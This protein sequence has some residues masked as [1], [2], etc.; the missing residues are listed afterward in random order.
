M[1]SQVERII[2]SIRNILDTTRQPES[3]PGLVDLNGV[4]EDLSILVMPET[5][6]KGIR[7]TKTFA[8]DLPLVYGSRSKLEE[9][10]LNLIDNAID[11]LPGAGAITIATRRVPSPE[12]L[13][14]KTEG[15]RRVHWVEVT[16]EDNGRG[17]PEALLKD[18][19]KPFYTTKALGKGTGLGLAI[20][21]EIVA[22]YHGFLTV[23]SEPQK[24]SAFKVLLPSLEKITA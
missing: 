21:Q 6:S 8:P 7:V 12:G 18:I 14:L 3:R 17:I 24:G 15:L 23:E 19:F 16:I 13:V 4:I 1:Q 11:A 9:V 20:S 22:G 10:C 5:I 2:T